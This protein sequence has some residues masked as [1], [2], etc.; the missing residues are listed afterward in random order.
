MSS[1]PHAQA[2]SPAIIFDT[3][4]GYHRTAALRGAIELDLFTAIGEGNT[5][6]AAIAKR[7]QASEKGTRV[8]CDFLTICGLLTKRENAYGLTIDS[9][10]FLNRHSPAYMGTAARF[11]ANPLLTENFVDLA[12]VV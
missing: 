1:A 12:S 7:I 4:N 10:A 9:G 6:V 2:P 5:T 8:L 3:L 11:L